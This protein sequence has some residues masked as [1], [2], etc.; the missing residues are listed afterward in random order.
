MKYIYINNSAC[1]ELSD[2]ETC[3]N[4]FDTST[5]VVKATLNDPLGVAVVGESWPLTMEYDALTQTYV[6]IASAEMELDVYS[7]YD[8]QV[9]VTTSTGKLIA[10]FNGKYK[11]VR[12]KES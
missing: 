6:A 11:A 12:R 3:D 4:D 7:V 10:T 8:L 5:A 1:L 9:V 2:L